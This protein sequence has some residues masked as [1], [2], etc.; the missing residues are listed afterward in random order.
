[1]EPHL[2]E[3][4]LWASRLAARLRL[5]IASCAEDSPSVRHG[6]LVEEIDRE[7]R[8]VSPTRRKPYLDALVERFPS[9]EGNRTTAASQVETGATP[10]TPEQLVAQLVEL[11]PTLSPETRAAFAKQ[12]ADVGLVVKEAAN[13]FF[14]KLPPEVTKRLGIP[15]GKQLHLERAAEML[16]TTTAL[17]LALDQVVWVIWKQVA[18]KTQIQKNA[19]ISKLAGPYLVGDTSVSTTQVN[20]ALERTR[21]LI[22]AFLGAI[23]RAGAAYARVYVASMGPEE[24]KGLAALEKKWNETIE[25]ASWKRFERMASEVASEP[26]IERKIQDAIA[27]EVEK[28]FGK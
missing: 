18:P 10:L 11:A 25:A 8:Q 15:A 26:A 5:L 19:E 28:L 23:G 24:I 16:A 4:A 9:W 13:P 17:A 22:A 6:Y 1:M 20:Q 14:D 12:L 2:S 21:R 7:L 27:V 3:E